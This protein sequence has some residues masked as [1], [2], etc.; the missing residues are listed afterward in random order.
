MQKSLL[1]LSS[2][3]CAIALL[4]ACG[5]SKG[6][7]G[8]TNRS[9]RD[10]LGGMQNDMNAAEYASKKNEN[11][12]LVGGTVSGLGGTTGGAPSGGGRTGENASSVPSLNSTGL[13]AAERAAVDSLP[14]AALTSVFR[15]VSASMASPAPAARTVRTAP[16]LGNTECVAAAHK[17]VFRDQECFETLKSGEQSASCNVTVSLDDAPAINDARPIS[18]SLVRLTSEDCEAGLCKVKA[19]DGDV[20]D[21][22]NSTDN[23]TFDLNLL[24]DCKEKTFGQPVQPDL[25]GNEPIAKINVKAQPDT[26]VSTGFLDPTGT[27][28][29]SS[30]PEL[31]EGLDL[32]SNSCDGAFASFNKLY[33]STS[34]SVNGL[35]DLVVS[36]KPADIAAGFSGEAETASSVAVAKVAG[37]KHAVEYAMT[38]ASDAGKFG[39]E[40]KGT[41]FGGGSKK[42]NRI[43]AGTT[44][45]MKLDF[46]KMQNAVE[47]TISAHA[48][49]D[50]D[51]D[52]KGLDDAAEN[53]KGM[54]VTQTFNSVALSDLGAR[55]VTLLNSFDMTVN[56]TKGKA[57]KES[58]VKG[59]AE[60]IVN[61]GGTPSISQRLEMNFQH[62]G[63]TGNRSVAFKV[64]RV[65]GSTLKFTGSDRG[66]DEDG[67]I[68]SDS[69]SFLLVKS[70]SGCKVKR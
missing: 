14:G 42:D 47:A 23:K 39:L 20:D 58:K 16:S 17:V 13:H 4:S 22:G 38:P 68:Q 19:L 56:P 53:A 9:P 60:I 37:S 6:E 64:E 12:K 59:Q 45:T 51:A 25:K 66:P 21:F 50:A 48:G 1:S 24:T 35:Y 63:K 40:M 57:E 5:G 54:L 61:A 33:A 67:K 65:D 11:S 69:G 52:A 8:D 41:L 18:T 44:M 26:T 70:A 28:G 15:S 30:L 46:D 34:S 55:S 32:E 31:F 62:E 10:L 36:A 43:Y 27:L 49:A 7:G 29:G 3:L 2:S